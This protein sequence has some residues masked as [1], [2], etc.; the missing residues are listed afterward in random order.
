MK[1]TADRGLEPQ[2]PPTDALQPLWEEL[3]CAIAASQAALFRGRLQEIEAAITVQQ[4]ICSKIKSSIEVLPSAERDRSAKSSDQ[5]QQQ[6]LVFAAT[7]SRMRRHLD[8]LRSV[9]DGPSPTYGLD[10]KQRMI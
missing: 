4:E 7:V 1:A 5:V 8:S 10:Q 2:L 9:L 3:A 6:N